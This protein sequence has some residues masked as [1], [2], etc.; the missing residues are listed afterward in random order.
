MRTFWNWKPHGL[1]SPQVTAA[2]PHWC[3]ELPLAC[4]MAFTPL[5]APAQTLDLHDAIRTY[6]TLTNTAVTMSGRAELRITG[7][8]DPLPQAF[9]VDGPMA[10]VGKDRVAPLSLAE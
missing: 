10:R 3:W 9:E 8:G 7:T 2:R 6:A 5:L 4:L 1:A